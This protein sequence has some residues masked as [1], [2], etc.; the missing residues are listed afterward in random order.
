MKYEAGG[1]QISESAAPRFKRH[2]HLM[3]DGE[4]D[5]KGKRIRKH[6]LKNRIVFDDFL[7]CVKHSEEYEKRCVV[8]SD[9]FQSP[10][11]FGNIS[12]YNKPQ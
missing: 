8:E 3:D 12:T 1:K 7:D 5:K 2:A 6:V 11:R 4:E 10:V 9:G